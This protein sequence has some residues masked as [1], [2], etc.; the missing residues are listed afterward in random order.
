MYL[1]LLLHIILE[2][3]YKNNREKNYKEQLKNKII[4]LKLKSIYNYL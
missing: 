1:M 4:S 3:I 2:K